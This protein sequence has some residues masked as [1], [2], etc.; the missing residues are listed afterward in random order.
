MPKLRVHSY[1]MSV[2]GFV[3][4]P[5]QDLDNPMG[6]GGGELHEWVFAT[7]FGRTMIGQ[8]VGDAQRSIDD[9]FLNRGVE[10]IGAT[11]MGRNMFGP[12]RGEWPDDE[13]KGW[14]GDTPPYHH[15]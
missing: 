4:G 8:P 11:I 2:D 7:P 9:D 10:N 14:W 3:A 5:D 15:D 6:V 1:S 13:W 12:I